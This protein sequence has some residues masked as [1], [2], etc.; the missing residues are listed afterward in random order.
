[1]IHRPRQSDST[2]L[3]AP[4]PRRVV[5][6]FR[7]RS[8]GP[9]HSRIPRHDGHPA[10]LRSFRQRHTDP[11]ACPVRPHLLRAVDQRHTV[12][13]R[14]PIGIPSHDDPYIRVRASTDARASQQPSKSRVRLPSR[15]PA[16]IRAG[17]WPRRS[18]L[19]VSSASR[20]RSRSELP[21]PSGPL[22]V[23]AEAATQTLPHVPSRSAD[24]RWAARR[25]RRPTCSTDPWNQETF[26]PLVPTGVGSSSRSG[27][28]RVRPRRSSRYPAV[29]LPF[30]PGRSADAPRCGRS[31]TSA[32][33]RA[34]NEPRLTP[35]HPQ[36]RCM[37]RAPSTDLYAPQSTARHPPLALQAA[38]EQPEST[39]HRHRVHRPPP[40]AV[41]APCDPPHSNPG[42]PACRRSPE[43]DS[44][45]S[46]MTRDP[47][48]SCHIHRLQSQLQ[49]IRSGSDDDAPAGEAD[50]HITS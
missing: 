28:P 50:F 2:R 1:M 15:V 27:R 33:R 32:S 48:I 35:A 37:S 25:S 10:A 47:K 26:V 16:H 30:R 19:R 20:F 39:K 8:S 40:A 41:V 24:R 43:D 18:T 3:S 38:R 12:T 13:P 44:N 21:A 9:P 22:F 34:S 29:F 11:N 7:D 14:A 45:P 42:R 36:A 17:S 31:H 49:T 6:T 46:V 23:S 4:S 5:P